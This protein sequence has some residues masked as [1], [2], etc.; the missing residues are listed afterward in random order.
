MKK[1]G[2]TNGDSGVSGYQ[3]GSNYIW[4]EFSTGSVYEYTYS[5]AGVSNVETMKQL[6]ESGSGLNG[7]INSHVKFKY[8]RKIR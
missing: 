4:V 8:S 6:A 5:S 1:Y 3:I 2:N 7:F